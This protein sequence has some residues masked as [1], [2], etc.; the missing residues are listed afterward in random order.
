MFYIFALSR[1]LSKNNYTF[2]A[3]DS[4]FQ[5]KSRKIAL[6]FPNLVKVDS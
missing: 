1:H 4:D 5:A 2:R 6:Y 3:E